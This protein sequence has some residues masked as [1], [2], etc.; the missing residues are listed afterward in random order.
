MHNSLLIKAFFTIDKVCI[1]K[2]VPCLLLNMKFENKGCFFSLV[3]DQIQTQGQQV[4]DLLL[5][6]SVRMM[7]SRFH[8]SIQSKETCPHQEQKIL[9]MEKDVLSQAERTDLAAV[10]RNYKYHQ[11]EC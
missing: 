10:Y 7:R 11:H 6:V 9:H 5:Q 1:Y 3:L 4:L 8:L 2:P